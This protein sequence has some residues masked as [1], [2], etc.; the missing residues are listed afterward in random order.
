MI[1]IKSAMVATSLTALTDDSLLHLN[2]QDRLWIV[3]L[4]TQY[5]FADETIKEILQL[6]SIMRPI[7]NVT[8]IFEV[9]IGLRTQLTAEVF[10]GI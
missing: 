9:N 4:R 2:T 3:T 7:Y 6:S 1:E 5:K 8:I 10:C